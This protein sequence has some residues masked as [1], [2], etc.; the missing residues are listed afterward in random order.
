MDE[1]PDALLKK[2][3]AWTKE[4]EW[5]ILSNVRGARAFNKESLTAI[6]FGCYA[7]RKTIDNIR[8]SMVDNGYKKVAFKQLDFRI[9]GVTL[10]QTDTLENE[11]KK[12][13]PPTMANP[14]WRF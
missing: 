14:K 6:Y 8:Q 10:R 4:Q 1:L 12:S 5:R 9:K 13:Q 2:R 7:T 3:T 11:N